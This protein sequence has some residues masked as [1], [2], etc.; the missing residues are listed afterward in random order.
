MESITL[1]I[2][3]MTCDHCVRAVSGALSSL[4]GVSVTEVGIGRAR[5]DFD[6]R[7]VREQQIVDAVEDE[8]YQAQV[9]R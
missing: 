5:L 8:G 1:S 4:P 7:R 6:E 2:Q 3:G 9:D